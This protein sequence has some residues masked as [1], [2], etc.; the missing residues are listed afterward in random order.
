MGLLRTKE[1]SFDCSPA[2]LQCLARSHAAS[3]KYI[4]D[5]SKLEFVWE[6]VAREMRGL[7]GRI[8]NE[9]WLLFY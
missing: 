9:R 3:V 1:N 8:L 6:R 4:H 5:F 7:V 2:C